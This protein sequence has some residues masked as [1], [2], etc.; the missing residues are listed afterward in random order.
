MTVDQGW[1]TFLR[2][3]AIIVYRFRRN[4]VWYCFLFQKKTVKRAARCNVL[5]QWPPGRRPYD[6]YPVNTSHGS[7]LCKTFEC[8][9]TW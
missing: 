1:R 3:R 9:V 8:S 7:D 6:K 2:S 5:A 4:C